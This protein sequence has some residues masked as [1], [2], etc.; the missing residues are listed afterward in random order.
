MDAVASES[1]YLTRQAEKE[2]LSQHEWSNPPILVYL[3]VVLVLIGTGV[4]IF[5]E[6]HKNSHGTMTPHE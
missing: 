6:R 1:A 3:I 5:L 2:L 4:S